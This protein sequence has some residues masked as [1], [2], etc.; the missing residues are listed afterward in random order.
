MP[1][2][3]SAFAAAAALVTRFA[4]LSYA[5]LISSIF[6]SYSATML[7][8]S[9]ASLTNALMVVSTSFLASAACACSVFNHIAEIP[10]LVEC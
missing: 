10:C 3:F 8:M 9:R 5:L 1:C 2:V 4:M 7:L 6:F